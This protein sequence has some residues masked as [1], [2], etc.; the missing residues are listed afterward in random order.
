MEMIGKTGTFTVYADRIIVPRI[1]YRE[2][3][4]DFIDDFRRAEEE[5]LK[6]IDK[7]LEQVKK[8]R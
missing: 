6:I 5:Q 7:L 4:L 1:V 8:W 3:N 2:R